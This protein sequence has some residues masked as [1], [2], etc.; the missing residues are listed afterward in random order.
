MPQV[1][2]FWRNLPHPAERAMK[3]SSEP[4]ACHAMPCA[5]STSTSTAPDSD[6]LGDRHLALARFLVRDR[7]YS[8]LCLD[9]EAVAKLR[10]ECKNR[11]LYVEV[12]QVARIPRGLVGDG[13]CC[14]PLPIIGLLLCDGHKPA[15]SGRVE[16]G[17]TV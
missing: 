8:Q 4:A 6:G 15:W 14:L 3:G 13:K 10:V 12:A 7:P 17:S 16:E 9:K 1:W 11:S 2:I 5:S